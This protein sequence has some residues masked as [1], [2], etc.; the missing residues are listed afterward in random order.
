MERDGWIQRI[1]DENDRRKKLIR[2]TEQVE[3]VWA[4]MVQCALRVRATAT[5]GFSEDEVD[6]VRTL[7][8]RM[9]ANLAGDQEMLFPSPEDKTSSV[10]S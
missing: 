3:P 9:R 1:P 5:E 2:V 6:A 4:K 7:L 10:D 8:G